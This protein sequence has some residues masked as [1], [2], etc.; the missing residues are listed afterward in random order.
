[1]CSAFLMKFGIINYVALPLL[2]ACSFTFDSRFIRHTNVR[3]RKSNV[4]T[5]QKTK[6]L[7]AGRAPRIRVQ[8]QTNLSATA[9]ARLKVFPDNATAHTLLIAI[10]PPLQWEG[11]RT[12]WSGLLHTFTINYCPS[13]SA[14]NPAARRHTENVHTQTHAPRSFDYEKKS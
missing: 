6:R 3:A 7:H 9:A 5:N 2:Y 14:I 8:P 13:P 11:S 12:I 10:N 4:H 1:M